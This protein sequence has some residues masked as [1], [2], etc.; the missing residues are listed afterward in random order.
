MLTRFL[1]PAL[2]MPVFLAAPPFAGPASAATM[3]DFASVGD[4]GRFDFEG[5]SGLPG[6]DDVRARLTLELTGRTADSFTFG[7]R[8]ENLTGASIA[9]A[10]LLSFGFDVDGTLASATSDGS[11]AQTASGQVPGFGFTDLCFLMGGGAC[12]SSAGAGLAIGSAPGTGSFSLVLVGP[13]ASLTLHDS[14]VRW[15]QVR[16]NDVAIQNASGISRGVAAE[17]PLPE[18]QSWALMVA[19]FGFVGFSLRRGAARGTIV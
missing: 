14:F 7:Y 5:L 13:L 19:G 6:R 1:I 8:I 9:T 17:V 16:A 15:R 12:A 10:R 11:F 2:F 4:K 18:P 3:L